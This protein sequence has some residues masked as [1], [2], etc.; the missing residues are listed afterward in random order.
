MPTLFMEY[1]GPSKSYLAE[2]MESARELCNIHGSPGFRSGIGRDERDG[3]LSARH[4]LG[5]M[6]VQNHPGCSFLSGDTA[7]P[8]SAYPEIIAMAKEEIERGGVTAYIFSHAEMET[9]I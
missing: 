3:I 2:V 8:V 1:H 9:S 4:H 6:I 7:V 5:E